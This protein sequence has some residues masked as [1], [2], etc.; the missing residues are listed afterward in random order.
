VAAIASVRTAGL[1]DLLVAAAQVADQAGAVAA[2]SLN[3]EYVDRPEG[4]P[5]DQ[6]LLI[7]AAIG[8]DD[9]VAQALSDRADHDRHMHVLVRVDADRHDPSCRRCHASPDCP[10]WSFAGWS[11]GRTGL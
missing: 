11:G 8:R 3:P 4:L 5:P 7:A 1:D 10:W 2:G 6:Q 9:D